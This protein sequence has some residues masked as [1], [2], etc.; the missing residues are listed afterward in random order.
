MRR[1]ASETQS[2]VQLARRGDPAAFYALFYGQINDLY[3]LLRSQGKD[4]AAACDEAKRRLTGAYRRFFRSRPPRRPDRWFAGRCGLKRFDPAAAGAGVS[5]ADAAAY[6][7]FALGA[8]NADY[9]HWLD[10]DGDSSGDI[11]ES[12]RSFV[13]Y[14]VGTA[15]AVILVGFLF[16]SQSVL[17]VSFGRYGA[18]Y[19][20][21]FPRI[22]AELWDMSGLVRT[23]DDDS[24]S[25]GGGE[26]PAPQGAEAAT[27]P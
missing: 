21:S 7:R 27:R 8:L 3:L 13:R 11:V 22:A 18:E 17:S 12:G 19:R 26:P 2:Y 10:Q 4:H 6:E 20:L 5:K 14:L 16:F 1:I 25:R 24:W 9:C 23:T 15:A